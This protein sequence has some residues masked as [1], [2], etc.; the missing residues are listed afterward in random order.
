M[1][2]W[3]WIKILE[4]IV[5]FIIC[6]YILKKDMKNRIDY[7][8][9][10]NNFNIYQKS[11]HHLSLITFILILSAC[12]LNATKFI[13]I[14][15]VFGPQFSLMIQTLFRISLTFYQIARLQYTFNDNNN[16]S[17]KYAYSSKIFYISYIYGVILT[18]Y[19]LIVPW[20]IYMVQL[21][22]KMMFECNY[23]FTKSSNILLLIMI[24]AYYLWDI[25][26]LLLY[27]NKIR[28]IKRKKFSGSNTKVTTKTNNNDNNDTIILGRINYILI[29]ITILTILYEIAGSL[30]LISIRFLNMNHDKESILREFGI[31][32]DSIVMM[33]IVHLMMEYNDNKY[34]KLVK[35]LFRFKLCCCF[36]LTGI[37]GTKQEYLKNIKTNN[38]G[39]NNDN[40]KLENR[41]SI[42]TKTVNALPVAPDQ[43]KQQSIDSVV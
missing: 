20:F 1:D 16:H 18:L 31:V 2:V 5:S 26:I 36:D 34:M 23:K 12:L 10:Y 4:H 24:S 33:F 30:A 21:H 41:K 14:L 25:P 35:I 42:D 40:K 27:I 8:L 22:Q 43:F 6:A 19:L 37:I 32:I 3:T 13:P 15:C 39:N 17:K 9:N 28:A 11:L 38:N 7:N 29:K